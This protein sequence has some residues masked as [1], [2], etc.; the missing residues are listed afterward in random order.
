MNFLA[1]DARRSA[2][3]VRGV[4]ERAEDEFQNATPRSET[5]LLRPEH[6]FSAAASGSA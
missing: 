5:A 6:T 1:L 3:A 4:L 2:D